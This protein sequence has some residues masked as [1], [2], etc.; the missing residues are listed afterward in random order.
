MGS[1]R[2]SP[3]TLDKLKKLRTFFVN[4]KESTIPEPP[5]QIYYALA[6]NYQVLR[7]WMR[8]YGVAPTSIRYVNDSSQVRGVYDY[9]VITFRSFAIPFEEALRFIDGAAETFDTKLF[10][11]VTKTGI[12]QHWQPFVK[13]ETE[14]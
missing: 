10:Y 11:P 2:L 14:K 1:R 7:Y 5:K 6:P 13:P 12:I 4:L 8:Q 9:K 3:G